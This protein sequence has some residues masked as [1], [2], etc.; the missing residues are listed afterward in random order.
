MRKY[1][2]KVPGHQTLSYL[3]K[4]WKEILVQRIWFLFPFFSLSMFGTS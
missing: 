2:E 3:T 1:N 4:I